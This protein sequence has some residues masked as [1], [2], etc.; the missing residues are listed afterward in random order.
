VNLV[1]RVYSGS[2][3]DRGLVE[4][5]RQTDFQVYTGPW[6]QL[7]MRL[8]NYVARSATAMVPVTRLSAPLGDWC[9]SW[10]RGAWLFVIVL[11]SIARSSGLRYS[12]CIA[13]SLEEDSVPGISGPLLDHLLR[14]PAQPFLM[15]MT[16]SRPIRF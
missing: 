9:H 7:V 13:R 10:L 2:R 15:F 12:C 8:Y 5:G 4:S 16:L 1:L 11:S 6:Y 14:K 3:A